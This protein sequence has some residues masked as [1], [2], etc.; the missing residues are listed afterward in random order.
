MAQLGERERSKERGR[1]AKDSGRRDDP[2]TDRESAN[3]GAAVEA[4]TGA[5]TTGFVLKRV[6]LA[7]SRSDGTLPR[8]RYRSAVLEKLLAGTGRAQV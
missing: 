6:N 3:P 4:K 1:H 5:V 7:Q 8:V 2:G